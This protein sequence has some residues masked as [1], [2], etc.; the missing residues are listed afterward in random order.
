MTLG[1]KKLLIVSFISRKELLNYVKRNLFVSDYLVTLSYRTVE[2][3][4]TLN[5]SRP[6][7][8]DVESDA[9]IIRP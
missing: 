1:D 7:E 5:H 2:D 9:L 8:K 6:G 3:M 4:K